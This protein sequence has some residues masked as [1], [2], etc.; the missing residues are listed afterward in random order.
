GNSDDEVVLLCGGNEI[1]RVNY[2]GG[3][4]FPDPTGA[5][6]NLDPGSFNATA[7]NTGS[8][9]CE[10]NTPYGSG[11]NGTPGAAN[12]SCSTPCT[13]PVVSAPTVTQPTCSVPTGTIVVNATGSGTLEYSADNGASWQA[14]S[15]FSGLAPGNYNIKVRLQNDPSC[16]SAYNQNPV[17]LNPPSCC[18]NAG[19]IIITEIMQ[20][21]SA[22]SDSNGEWVEVYNTTGTQI[23]LN[24][25]TIK[26]DGSDNHVISS[27]VVVPA[28]GYAVL[29]IND[30]AAQNGGVT[31][32]YEYTGINLGNS[33]DEVV[34]LCGGNEIDRVNYDGGPSFPDPTGASMNLDPGSF[35]ATAN[36]IGSNWCES[37]TPY[38]SGDNG[39]PGAA[40][41]SCSTPCT[42]PVVSAP[43]VTQPTCS[44]PSG[45]IV[46]NATG[47]GTLEY[48][49]DNGASWQASS[50]FSGLA[51]GSYNIKVRL[52][53]DPS[54]MT[55]YAGNSVSI[56]AAPAAPTVNAP[57]VTQPT[58]AIPTG[59]IVVNATGTGTLEYSADNGASWQASSTFSGLAP[60]SYNIKVRLQNDPSCMTAYAQNPVE[61]LAP[62]GC[63]TP[64]VVS[65][66]SVTQPTCTNPTGT[67]VVNATGTGTLEYSVDNG[68]S[69]QTSNTF[70]GLAPGSYN[71]KV[72]LQ[73]DPSCMS[74]Y[75]QN[76]V[77]L[78]IAGGN[79][80]YTGNVFF[81]TQTQ[82]NA[83]SSCY[84]KVIGSVTFL[85]SNI[86]DLGP[87]A[88]V[89]E[90]TGNV[91][92]QSTG[93]TNMN[94]LNSL[95]TI[96]G[97]M[98]ILYNF[99]LTSLSGL[100]ALSSVGGLFSMYYNFSLADCCAIYDLINGGGIGGATL[101]FFNAN[102]CNSA[103]QILSNCGSPLI[104]G[105][106]DYEYQD[107]NSISVQRKT[108]TLFPNPTKGEV[109]IG[110]AHSFE[111]GQVKIVDF[112]GRT[113][114]SQK[115]QSNTTNQRV[116]LTDWQ[117]GIYLVQVLLDGAALTQKLVVN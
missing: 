21:P 54:C 30:N 82:L 70:S 23:D 5:S 63:C 113:V 81:A 71:I 29:G 85:G 28:N 11:D 105:P 116:N 53:N 86:T 32:N 61:L 103:A 49:A 117:P 111:V 38:G 88:N 19:D 89:T 18:P 68:A 44:V 13:P 62:T 2:D 80:T 45:T 67:I 50:T 41:I 36:N 114:L 48:S 3:P 76:P 84:T 31:V 97:N 57:T 10:S 35:N 22:V 17:V 73:N 95:T 52:Q 106:T 115:L 58:C 37:N 66:P 91:V 96:G 90:V 69:W 7:N 109:T 24:G 94:G 34:L 1:D 56:N 47:S 65:V 72:R 104:A 46:V 8:N 14:S 40:N 51:P 78:T 83:W 98:T 25:W 16:M 33:D 100:N 39:T 101:I 64:P 93:I 55:A 60:G 87:F 74:T 12:I 4:N 15:T 59:T 77:V 26:D 75:A 43:T 20:N 27:S 42:P 108:M 102:G 110:I 99:S 107:A 79:Q 9:W 92:I 112:A 6:M